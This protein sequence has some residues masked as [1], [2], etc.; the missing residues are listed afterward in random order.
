[1]CTFFILSGIIYFLFPGILFLLAAALVCP[2]FHSFIEL[3]KKVK[4]FTVVILFLIGV[5]SV[6]SEKMSK[7]DA[8][9]NINVTDQSSSIIHNSA[10]NSLSSEKSSTSQLISSSSPSS[11]VSTSESSDV[12]DVSS[13]TSPSI[14]NEQ[15]TISS[16]NENPLETAGIR[17][18]SL[19]GRGYSDSGREEPH[20]E[21]IIG[22][23]AISHSDYN[24]QK[25]DDCFDTPWR[26]PIYN[27]DKQ[28][29]VENGDVEHKTEVIVKSQELEH[30]GYGAYSGYLVVERTDT[31]E[32]FCI[33]VINFITKPYWTY[34]NIREASRVGYCIAEFNQVSDY[35]P[36]SRNN[37]KVDLND[38]E[39]VLI[40]GPTGSYGEGGP[41]R[42]TNAVEAIVFKEW[43][44]GYGGVSVFFNDKDLII[45]Y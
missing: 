27:Q 5:F 3:P 19:N 17:D 22:Y 25:T 34:D 1:M 37:E 30:E 2:A 12:D 38:G 13:S 31:K 4:I 45:T 24:L 11:S 9:K 40:V 35:Y 43:K 10:N 14:K 16:S 29:Y 18:Q 28:F 23:I 26:I 42:N 8:S 15:N 7:A 20:Y 41:D 6:P 32:T 21:N 36:V 44:N 33:N 39:H